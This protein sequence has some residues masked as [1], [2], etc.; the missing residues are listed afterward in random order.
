MEKKMKQIQNNL[1]DIKEKVEKIDYDL[2]VE[3]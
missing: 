3:D 2:N 1:E